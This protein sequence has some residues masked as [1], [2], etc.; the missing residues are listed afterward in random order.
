MRTRDIPLGAALV[1]VALVL[2]AGFVARGE[3]AATT[4]PRALPPDA[5]PVAPVAAGAVDSGNLELDKLSRT[6]RE[7]PVVDLFASA[8]VAPPPA[9]TY[10]AK[11]S[12]PPAPAAPPLPFKFLGRLVDGDKV[13]VFLDRNGEGVSASRGDTLQ[14]TYRVEGITD[15]EIAFTYLP[16]GTQQKLAIPAPN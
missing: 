12:P 5:A 6:R 15:S 1:V 16:L 8:A 2:L 10:S 3:D 11:P 14:N 13:V 7:T 9:T 4:P